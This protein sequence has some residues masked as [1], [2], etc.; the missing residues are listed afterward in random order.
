MIASLR[1]MAKSETDAPAF[2]KK[3]VKVGMRMENQIRPFVG[4]KMHPIAAST[5]EMRRLKM[6]V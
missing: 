1:R 3:R 2:E 5:S 6:K 4:R